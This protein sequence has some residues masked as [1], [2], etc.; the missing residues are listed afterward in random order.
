VLYTV[1]L[2]LAK[3]RFFPQ[4][5]F[6]ENFLTQIRP[7]TVILDEKTAFFGILTFNHLD[8]HTHLF[9]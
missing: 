8:P 3:I 2:P 4:A 5:V 1:Q 9:I 7:I 6:A